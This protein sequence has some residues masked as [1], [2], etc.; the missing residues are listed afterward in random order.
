MAFARKFLADEIGATGI[1]YG[2]IASLIAMAAMSGF[3]ELGDVVDSS[4]GDTAAK[5]EDIVN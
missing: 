3:D 1:E 5:Y 2:L 4:Y